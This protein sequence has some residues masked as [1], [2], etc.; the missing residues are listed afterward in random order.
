MLKLNKLYRRFYRGEDIIVERNY[1]SG[2]W[3]DTTELVPNAVMNNQISNQ[4]V[5]LGNGPSRLEFEMNLIKNHKG[6]L[7]GSR[8]LQ[9]YGCNALY[10]DYAPHF[11]IARGNNIIDDLAKSSYVNDHIVYTSSIH[12]LEHPGKFY[13]IPHDPYTDAGTTAL[14]IAA[15]DGHKKI[16]MLGFDNQDTSGHNYNVYA[17]TPGYPELKE[18]VLDYKWIA[19]KAALFNTYNETEFIR[20]TK[21]GLE[22]IPESWKYCPNFRAI[23]Y[24]QFALEADL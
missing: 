10:R 22:P 14:Y 6:G 11:L 24:N 16:F 2:V 23:N 18:T 3:H 4:A 7:L 8:A 15:F 17:G 1:E 12:L 21:K 19:D 20:V 13:L 9:T 5:V